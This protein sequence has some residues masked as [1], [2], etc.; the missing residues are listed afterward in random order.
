M[1]RGIRHVRSEVSITARPFFESIGFRVLRQQVV[2][3]RGVSLRNFRMERDIDAE[4]E[5]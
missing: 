3:R 2:E 1:S 4:P 5:G